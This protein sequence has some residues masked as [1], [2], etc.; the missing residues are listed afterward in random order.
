MEYSTSRLAWVMW[1]YDW[2]PER[3]GEI[4][5]LVRATDGKGQPQTAEQR[6]VAPPGANGC[7]RVV[8]R[9]QA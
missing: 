5:L 4:P 2:Q 7:R 3:P 1:R 6:G 9:L 8:A